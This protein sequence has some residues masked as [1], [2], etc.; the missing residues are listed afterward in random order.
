M[1]TS[2]IIPA[3]VV[4]HLRCGL[5]SE[6][7]SVAVEIEEVSRRADRETRPKLYDESLGRFDVI[8]ELLDVVGW[9]T[10]ETERSVEVDIDRHG[11]AV[12]SALNG[13]LTIARDHLSV[14][15]AYAGAEQQRARASCTAREIEAFLKCAGLPIVEPD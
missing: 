4:A 15:L 5:H 3:E 10:A 6:I 11:R 12:V 8:R 1:S 7:G 14:D 2:L 13:L 9:T